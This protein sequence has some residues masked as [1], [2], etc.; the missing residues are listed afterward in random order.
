MEKFQILRA[1]DVEMAIEAAK[2]VQTSWANTPAEEKFKI[3]NR[4]AELIDAN[5]EKIG[6]S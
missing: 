4:I 2:S 3:M 1:S 6:K 5:R